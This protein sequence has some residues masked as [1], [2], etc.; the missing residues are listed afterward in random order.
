[1]PLAK[2]KWLEP[3]QSRRQECSVSESAPS[4]ESPPEGVDRVTIVI[5]TFNDD[6]EHLRTSVDSAVVQ[7]WGNL[8]VIVVDDGSTREDTRGALAQL[9]AEVRV[10]RQ[11][12]GGVGSARNTGIAAA[13]GDI[14]VCLDADDRIDPHYVAEAVRTLGQTGTVVAFPFCVTFGAV[15]GEQ[16]TAPE[17]DA[18]DALRGS[19]IFPPSAFRKSRWEEIGGFYTGDPAAQEDWEFWTRMLRDGGFARRVPSAVFHWRIRENSRSSIVHLA[20]T[21]AAVVEANHGHEA[22][23]LAI[24]LKAL[25]EAQAKL[26]VQKAELAVWGR[27]TAPARALVS[28]ARCVGS[29]IR[30]LVGGRR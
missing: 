21:R 7:T 9:P 25:D 14:I 6:P 30:T 20:A 27:R 8:E 17:V 28:R 1:M 11:P 29:R 2:A 5:P 15:A 19:G 22:K 26:E 4:R 16:P 23:M 10:I 24:A 3:S 13:S 12:N 18:V